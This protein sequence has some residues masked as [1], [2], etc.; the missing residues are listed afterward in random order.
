[1]QRVSA[2]LCHKMAHP[3]CDV[4]INHRGIDTKRN[5][6]GLLYDR[7]TAMGVRSFL[8]SMNMK[9]GDRLF[10]HID[11]AIV[12]SKVGV[13]VFSP[14]YCES[15]FCLHEL[16]LLMESKKRVIPIFYNVKPSQLVVKDNKTCPAKELRRFSLALEE[17]KYTVGL[18]FDPL[19]GDWSEMLKD[20]SEA[21]IMNLLEVDEEESKRMKRRP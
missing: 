6:A 16:A 20:A 15:Y 8:D 2:T 12:G 7:L 10:Q 17:A 3:A 13:A 1:M 18:T 5:I 11:R 4:F 19:K 9:P 14:R 21:V